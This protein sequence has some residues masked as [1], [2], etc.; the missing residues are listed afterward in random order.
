[1]KSEDIIKLV[2]SFSL[3]QIS[4]IINNKSELEIYKDIGDLFNIT[5]RD[6]RSNYKTLFENLKD[7]E[8]VIVT[9]NKEK[10]GI[11]IKYE[12]DSK[13]LILIQMCLKLFAA[14][15]ENYKDK[16]IKD[17]LFDTFSLLKSYLKQ[18]NEIE[19]QLA[20]MKKEK[21]EFEKE[22]N[23]TLEKYKLQIEVL[24]SLVNDME[25]NINN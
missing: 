25:N 22:S 2:S 4:Q 24:E 13:N 21:E 23:E 20:N 18:I 9:N 16:T 12:S 1:M 19:I 10:K 6:L 7:D 8:L 11:L 17:V 5:Q 14:L 3:N 15:K